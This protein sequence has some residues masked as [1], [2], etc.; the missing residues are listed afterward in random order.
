MQDKQTTG[1]RICVFS[2]FAEN[3]FC[4]DRPAL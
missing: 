2:D 3:P 1:T 4:S